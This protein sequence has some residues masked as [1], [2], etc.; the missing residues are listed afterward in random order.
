MSLSADGNSLYFPI[1][2]NPDV[3]YVR[4]D[5]TLGVVTA[6]GDASSG[7]PFLAPSAIDATPDGRLFAL[8]QTSAHYAIDSKTGERVIVSK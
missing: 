3:S 4:I 5:L 2:G 7:P 8:D 1:D 6:L